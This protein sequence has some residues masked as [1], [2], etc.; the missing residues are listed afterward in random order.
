MTA[1]THVQCNLWT[2]PPNLNICW[3]T[4][5]LAAVCPGSWRP[6]SA[7]SHLSG[8]TLS[9]EKK[10]HEQVNKSDFMLT[11]GLRW[12][13]QGPQSTFAGQDLFPS[14]TAARSFY[15]LVGNVSGLNFSYMQQGNKRDLQS[16]E[17]TG[18]H[19]WGS[20]G[21]CDGAALKINCKRGRKSSGSR[22]A[23]RWMT[24]CWLVRNRWLFVRR[25]TIRRFIHLIFVCPE[26][27]QNAVP[28]TC[29]RIMCFFCLYLGSLNTLCSTC[30][31]S[32]SRPERCRCQIMDQ[33]PQNSKWTWS[34]EGEDVS[35]E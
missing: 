1:L 14:R 17:A 21:C 9:P 4:E 19:P 12:C 10:V 6:R 13:T 26:E 23:Q 27:K 11:E 7:F 2:S 15:R 35:Q 20:S 8:G 25:S 5:L 33:C 29:R 22:A 34:T 16:S 24:S 3:V 28:L 32:G 18:G 31:H 30:D